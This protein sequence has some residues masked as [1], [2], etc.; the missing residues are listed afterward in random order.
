[1]TD[2]VLIFDTTLRDGEQSPGYS[3]DLDG[4]LK[5]AEMLDQMGVDI[6]EAGFPA[7][8]KGDFESVHKVSR[9]AKNAIVAGLCRAVQKDIDAVIEATKPARRS[10][11]H[12][13][14]ST[15][16]LH[17]KHKL[18]ME[19]SHVLEMISESVS[20]ARKHCDDVEW[21]AEDATRSEHDFLCRAVEAAI[22]AGAT[23]VNIPDTV[24]YTVP[25][26][27]FALIKMLMQRVP[28]IGKAVISTH[29]HN[30]LGL[31]VANS[32]AG[33]AAGARQVECTINGI[34]ERAGNAAME[35]IVMAFRTRRDILPFDT[36]IDSKK[37]M[38][39][40][41]LLTA[42]TG[43]AVQPNKAVVGANAFAHESG[44]HQD[45]MLKHAST[46]E[47]MT[48][49]SIGRDKSEL[50]IGKHSGRNAF[51]GKLA[52][53]GFH[54]HDEELNTAF[55]RF[56]DLA[57][58][59]KKITDDDLILVVKSKDGLPVESIRFVSLSVRSGSVGP[60]EAEL[61]VEIDGQRKKAKA[62]GKGPVDACFKAMRALVPHENA[63][64]YNYELKALSQGSD[65]KGEVNV[66]LSERGHAF[67]G[68]GV[69]TDVI[70]A[71]CR[72]YIDALNK[73]LA[74]HSVQY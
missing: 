4:K 67:N 68:S 8:S 36:G 30:D 74:A 40:S 16:P 20:Y 49:E 73:L 42:I 53:L 61:E 66:Q 34:G 11:I 64:L 18:Q 71:S 21:S 25:D 44:I 27:Y 5:M 57:D 58:R 38:A 39:A 45:G 22:K 51:R 14:I 7:A 52:A 72:A 69:D 6:I 26:E 9:Q 59:K 55:E 13:F 48:P 41:K 3:M 47:I 46:Y 70:V 54:L 23:T 10:R 12:T 24:G 2:R 63:T 31:A 35:E 43:F 15:S 1:M 29:C 19:P 50:V 37:I 65:A 60:Q 62:V 33:V 56:K 28:N 32:I 17:M